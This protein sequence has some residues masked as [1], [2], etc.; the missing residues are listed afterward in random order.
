MHVD[1]QEIVR[2]E[3]ITHDWRIYLL[4]EGAAKAN[5]FQ[6]NYEL[7]KNDFLILNPNERFSMHS[8]EPALVLAITFNAVHLDD[9]LPGIRKQRFW[10]FPSSSADQTTDSI[11]ECRQLLHRIMITSLFEDVDDAAI[12]AR[13]LAL[14]SYLRSHYLWHEK[15]RSNAGPDLSL[16]HI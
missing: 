4:L 1:I 14:I 13:G 15:T 10:N 3:T 16:I 5:V 8:V 6:S 11:D 9:I 12:I 2:E 7:T